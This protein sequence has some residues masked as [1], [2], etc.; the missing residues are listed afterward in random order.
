M[1][2]VYNN[3][4][5]TT[6]GFNY[7][8]PQPLDD[9]MVV[10]DFTDLAEL[11]N[12]NIA[13]V[14]MQVYVLSEQKAYRLSGNTD[15]VAD[16]TWQVDVAENT[17]SEESITNLITEV[18]NL[19]ASTI[20]T[21]WPKS[22]Q[23]PV[24]AL[25]TFI[26]VHN[27]L[28]TVTPIGNTIKVFPVHSNATTNTF[29]FSNAQ[30]DT[31]I[32]ELA[33]NWIIRASI[34]GGF[35]VQN[36]KFNTGELPTEVSIIDINVADGTA[37]RTVPLKDAETGNALSYYWEYD[38]VDKYYKLNQVFSKNLTFLVHEYVKNTWVPVLMKDAHRVDIRD[39]GI[40]RDS[41]TLG[42]IFVPL[43]SFGGSKQ[44]S[45]DFES[46]ADDVEMGD[47]PTVAPLNLNGVADCMPVLNLQGVS[48]VNADWAPCR[49]YGDHARTLVYGE[50]LQYLYVPET[51][52]N[53]IINLRA[54]SG[55]VGLREFYIPNNTTA[56]SGYAFAGANKLS[57]VRNLENSTVRD[58][59]CE[60]F[61]ANQ[62]DRLHL[63]YKPSVITLHDACFLNYHNNNQSKGLHIKTLFVSGSNVLH[64]ETPIGMLDQGANTK[65]EKL[66]SEY[67][68]KGCFRNFSGND[69]N[70]TDAWRNRYTLE[71]VYSKNLSETIDLIC[72]ENS[73]M[74]PFFNTKIRPA[75]KQDFVAGKDR[76]VY[77]LY[78]AAAQLDWF[79]I[80][81]YLTR[82]KDGDKT[83]LNLPED[84][85]NFGQGDYNTPAH[86][87]FIAEFNKTC[88]LV[89][90]YYKDD[91]TNNAATYRE[92]LA[93][94]LAKALEQGLVTTDETVQDLYIKELIKEDLYY[95][96]YWAS[97]A[98][99]NLNTLVKN[100][101]TDFEL[102]D[103]SSTYPALGT[104]TK[105]TI[106]YNYPS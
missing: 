49:L 32:L 14:G 73:Y 89:Y 56:I 22:L 55:A 79:L 51:Y 24:F 74:R 40:M 81:Q 5:Q 2:K 46:D 97:T 3:L 68:Q 78:Y 34:S 28:G 44:T 84:Y 38:A 102:V 66:L 18:A 10:Q 7:V 95:C 36:S 93:D 80:K 77:Y 47:W 13:Y 16:A 61:T 15:N 90:S 6:A 19:K 21:S 43:K 99:N 62:L 101:I 106:I 12:G 4:I 98:V 104:A 26:F 39:I 86:Q 87:E 45:T 67:G 11:V 94:H 1:G 23:I 33:G 70:P 50:M 54:C 42:E 9:R 37:T 52:N 27:D 83:K 96:V 20:I 82:Y 69:V 105:P 57:L 88:E 75:Y 92:G 85:K 64:M 58:I 30:L 31:S 71:L 59:Y 103:Y 76:S 48:L 29:E 72:H 17:A 60:A 8:G 63:P 25:G 53:L 41:P 65:R 91:T 100:D 35:F